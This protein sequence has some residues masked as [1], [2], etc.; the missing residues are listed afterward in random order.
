MTSFTMQ[1]YKLNTY[2]YVQL[3]TLPYLNSTSPEGQQQFEEP[4]APNKEL[5]HAC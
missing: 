4:E 2:E 1:K 5:I 3:S